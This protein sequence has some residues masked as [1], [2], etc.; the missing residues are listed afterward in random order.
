MT[1]GVV[2]FCAQADAVPSPARSSA[3]RK[4][5]FTAIRVS[6]PLYKLR[7]SN[8]RSLRFCGAGWQPNA[9]KLLLS[10]S[11]ERHFDS[12]VCAWETSRV[13]ARLPEERSVVC[14]DAG[15]SSS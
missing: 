11:W 8:L 5:H 3:R 12:P 4:D 15:A 14:G 1:M 10:C 2:P 9:T 6:Q 7:L 13:E